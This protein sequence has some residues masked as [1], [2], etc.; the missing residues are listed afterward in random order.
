MDSVNVP[1]WHST[2]CEDNVQED[3]TELNGGWLVVFK[4][5][6]GLELGEFQGGIGSR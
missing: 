6:R 3:L 4:V 2:A 1:F 5:T